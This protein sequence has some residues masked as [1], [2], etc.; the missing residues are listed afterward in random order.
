MS[1]NKNTDYFEEANEVQNCPQVRQMTFK[2]VDNIKRE[3]LFRIQFKSIMPY[4]KILKIKPLHLFEF[5]ILLLTLIETFYYLNKK[6]IYIDKQCKLYVQI[7]SNIQ[8]TSCKISVQELNKMIGGIEQK[9]KATSDLIQENSKEIKNINQF[10][11]CLKVLNQQLYD[12]K[13]NIALLPKILERFEQDQKNNYIDF[14]KFELNQVSSIFNYIIYQEQ[15]QESYFLVE[16]QKIQKENSKLIDQQNLEKFDKKQIGAD[17]EYKDLSPHQYKNNPQQ[18]EPSVKQESTIK[19]I[20]YVQLLNKIYDR[21]DFHKLDFLNKAIQSIE[22]LN[23]GG[24]DHHIYQKQKETL[25]PIE[26][27]LNMLPQIS[28]NYGIYLK[29]KQSQIQESN[30][31]KQQKFQSIEINQLPE[32]IGEFELKT[33]TQNQVSQIINL[34]W[35]N[36]QIFIMEITKRPDKDFQ[37]QIDLIKYMIKQ[38]IKANKNHLYKESLFKEISVLSED[39]ENKSPIN[40]KFILK[41]DYIRNLLSK[42]RLKEQFETLE[43]L[44]Y[45]KQDYFKIKKQLQ[46]SFYEEMLTFYKI[47]IAVPNDS[48]IQFYPCK[49]QEIRTIQ[50]RIHVLK[51]FKGQIKSLFEST[52]NKLDEANNILNSLLLNWGVIKNMKS[53]NLSEEKLKSLQNQEEFKNFQ[54]QIERKI[55]K[56]QQNLSVSGIHQEILNNSFE[57]NKQSLINLTFGVLMKKQEIIDK[58]NQLVKYYRN[59]YDQIYKAVPTKENFYRYVLYKS[60]KFLQGSEMPYKLNTLQLD[61]P[62]ENDYEEYYLAIRNGRIQEIIELINYNSSKKNEQLDYKS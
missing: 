43:R 11:S 14:I 27:E 36:I 15:L 29:Q 34:D 16:E 48:Q 13:I 22:T 8:F 17:S 26:Y 24:S 38:F 2:H 18:S 3:I 25:T 21:L 5:D 45:V 6:K 20:N 41:Q 46:K 55:Y 49:L 42:S 60:L 56:L 1:T 30:S 54:K 50:I 7:D 35:D 62:Y 10:N 37:N 28:N 40:M 53:H 32:N 4:E 31:S 61:M 33:N 39:L 57:L 9:V 23:S 59:T 52:K 44:G 51:E 19:R 12:L 47:K 58:L